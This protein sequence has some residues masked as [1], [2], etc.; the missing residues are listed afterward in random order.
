M[1]SGVSKVKL[2]VCV[3]LAALLGSGAYFAWT[4]GRIE[5]HV[6][7]LSAEDASVAHV[8]ELALLEYG[9]PGRDALYDFLLNK[10]DIKLPPLS[11]D[12]G[13]AS[14]SNKIIAISK[15]GEIRATGVVGPTSEVVV[16]AD[17]FTPAEKICTPLAGIAKTG[18]SRI[19]ACAMQPDFLLKA[20]EIDLVYLAPQQN[21]ARITLRIDAEDADL[22]GS[23][24]TS[25]QE[26]RSLLKDKN[27]KSVRLMPRP[28]VR[29]A[30]LLRFACYLHAAGVRPVLVFG[31]PETF[32]LPSPSELEELGR[33][34]GAPGESEQ[35]RA[36]VR[37]KTAMG[38]LFAYDTSK[39]PA[40][41][42]NAI[43]DWSK[44]LVKN[45][46]YIYFDS[47]TGRYAF[48]A[49]ASAAEIPHERYWLEK[50]RIVNTEQSG[51]T[52]RKEEKR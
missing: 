28:G 1:N 52:E 16:L 10:L 48:N 18:A 46:D 23:T 50:L 30:R 14:E 11:F 21:V 5:F 22:E 27:T 29:Y 39:S 13:S 6:Q 34:L 3:V 12:G 40:Q 17:S 45:G 32:G 20:L 49:A 42:R 24:V 8:S 4:W 31:S 51:S 2:V 35:A 44:W 43:E 26:I 9:A 36:A 7:R 37:L 33:S 41:N 38:D 25:A 47:V 15:S 19:L